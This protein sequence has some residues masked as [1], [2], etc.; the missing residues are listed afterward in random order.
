MRNKRIKVAAIL[1]GLTFAVMLALP[2]LVNIDRFRPQLESSL[3]SSLGR[4]VHVGHMKLSLLAGGARVEQISVSDDPAFQDGV[5]LQAKS[6]GVGVS[7]LS[8]ILSRSIHVT[9]LT[10]E[11][12]KM[13]AIQSPDGKWNFASLGNGNGNHGDS[14]RSAGT[15]LPTPQVILDHLRISNATIELVSGQ[16]GSQ[17]TTLRNIDVDLR[18]VSLDGAMALVI[19]AHTGTGK[20]KI[21]GEAGPIN[22]ADP[23]QTPF[24]ASITANRVDL[25]QIA[26]LGSSS[27]PGGILTV[28]ATIKSD[29]KTVHSEGRASADKLRLVHGAEPASQTV[30]LHYETNY[31][32]AQK[33]GVIRNGQILAGKG[34]ASLSGSYDN[35][36]NS[37]VIHARV[38]GTQLPVESVEGFLPA[39]GV[40][41]P[42]GSKLHGGMVTANLS[43]DGPVNR[44]VTSGSVQIANAHLAG[45]DLGSKLSALPGMSTQ[46]GGS[47]DRDADLSIMNLGAH[48]RIAPEGTY[49][50]GLDGQFGGIGGITGNGNISATN[51]LQF[52]MVAHVA[53]GGVVRA[54]MN[55]VGMRNLPNDI[56]FEVVGTTSVPVII[57]DLGGMAKTTAK[58]EVTNAAVNAG[59]GAALKSATHAQSP[60]TTLVQTTGNKK[61]G[62]F[63]SLF[64]H[65]ANQSNTNNG[66][67]AA[68]Q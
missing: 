41:L 65:K 8:L 43:V 58:G 55:R 68:A 46:H 5:F 61:T 60:V 18:N 62:F 10:L 12:P 51:H 16:S 52:S 29:G 22:V 4:E 33:T 39:L 64:H 28:D 23:E 56:P 7:F 17:E 11:E 36:G 38:A 40:V 45:F 15:M 19:S 14:A 25:G 35:H 53:S 67:Q 42:S 9:S 49:V 50:S 63:H 20:L 57:P 59:K 26:S 3:A 48:L 1:S 66:M 32:V 31:V 24:H 13:T 6:L 34:K 44:I 2:S 37:L 27:G 54:G 47:H 21:E 30:S